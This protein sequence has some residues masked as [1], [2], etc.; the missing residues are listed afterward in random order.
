MNILGVEYDEIVSELIAKKPLVV[1]YCITYNH[2]SY[3]RNALEG[4]VNQIVPFEMK[5]IVID[6]ASTD[7]TTEIIK[8]YQA[9]YP[10]SNPRHN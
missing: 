1:V 4:F 7:G 9:A 10:H 2:A 6:D 3:I 5:V 8:E